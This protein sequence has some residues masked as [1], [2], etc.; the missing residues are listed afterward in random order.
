MMKYTYVNREFA[1]LARW[2]SIRHWLSLYI[3][4]PEL[5]ALLFLDVG[6][7]LFFSAVLCGDWLGA[8]DSQLGFSWIWLIFWWSQMSWLSGY[9]QRRDCLVG[10]ESDYFSMSGFDW[11]S[12][13][14][15]LILVQ[16]LG[17][18][19]VLPWVGLWLGFEPILCAL[20][21]CVWLLQSPGLLLMGLVI[22]LMVLGLDY[23]AVILWLI[24]LPWVL[25]VSLWTAEVVFAYRWGLSIIPYVLGL[26]AWQI[27]SLV[28]LPKL[29]NHLRRLAYM[30]CLIGSC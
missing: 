5:W 23:G 20:F 6:L 4:R 28:L 10:Y 9:F 22:R 15:S 14:M 26:L 30:K 2:A 19:L 24:L 8:E 27:M 7:K 25:P 18:L 1:W 21:A 16:S 17:W 3:Q 13:W 11:L 12:E 29:L